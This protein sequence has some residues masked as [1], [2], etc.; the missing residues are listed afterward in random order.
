MEVVSGNFSARAENDFGERAYLP[1]EVVDLAALFCEDDLELGD[2][3]GVLPL[4][5]VHLDHALEVHLEQV[6]DLLLAQ[7]VHHPL[8]LAP[9]L[10][11][12]R[13]LGL[14]LVD[15]LNNIVH[16]RHDAVESEPRNRPPPKKIDKIR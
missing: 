16:L 10:L 3:V 8:H 15:L 2:A 11:C 13:K 14:A 1:G 5:G 9:A 12:R 4:L 6:L 7:S